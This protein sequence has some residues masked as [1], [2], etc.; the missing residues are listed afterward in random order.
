MEPFPQSKFLTLLK[1]H[2]II[3]T[4]GKSAYSAKNEKE[5]IH[6]KYWYPNGYIV[7]SIQLWNW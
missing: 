1:S 4:Q 7:T 2:Y 6:E 3:R 5:G